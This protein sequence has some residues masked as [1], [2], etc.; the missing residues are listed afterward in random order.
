MKI[1]ISVGI[2]TN[3]PSRD[4]E[5]RLK[6]APFSEPRPITAAAVRVNLADKSQVEAIRDR[7]SADN[8]QDLAWEYYDL[9][10]EVGFSARLIGSVTSRVRLYPAYIAD[11]ENEPI[12][13]RAVEGLDEDVKKATADCLR[14][15]GTGSGGLSG[16]LRDASMNLFITGECYIV[17]QP[18]DIMKNTPENW[19]IRSVDEI[20]TTSGRNSAAFVKPRKNAQQS[21]YIRLTNDSFV[22]R[23]WRMHPRYSDEA[24]SSLKSLLDLMDELLL[25]NK[26][27]RKNLKSRLNAGILYIPD[28]I[29]N[30]SQSDGDLDDN[31]DTY[32]ELSDDNSASFEDELLDAMTTPISDE[33]SASSIVPLIFRGPADLAD[34]IRHIVLEQQSDP[35]HVERAKVVL[36]RI[37]AGLDIP[38]DVV[39]GIGDSKYAN[40]VVIEESLYKSHIEPLVL[41]IVD[42]LTVVFLRPV[43]KAMGHKEDIINNIVIWYDPSPITTKPSKSEAA[44]YGYEAGTISGAAWRREHGFSESDSPTDMEI[45][46]RLAVD[47]GLLS[48]PVTEAL[49][50]TLIPEVMAKVRKEGIANSP[51]GSTLDAVISNG[52]QAREASEQ[53]SAEPAPSELLEP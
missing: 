44:N 47:R 34:K 51:S 30:I 39:A 10:G 29:S 26:I 36:D 48:E 24:D 45:G 15:L 33:S 17:K 2:F 53:D 1:G 14:L 8:W 11:E 4:S 46:T 23:I 7:R 5:N 22:G 35:Q 25:L 3:K 20:V 6:A 50:R 43:L 41:L 31:T 49:L 52:T 19:Q 12:H 27:S 37:L 42:A 9:I 28:E 38:K 21:E 13:I 16:L 32:A 40:A 18:A